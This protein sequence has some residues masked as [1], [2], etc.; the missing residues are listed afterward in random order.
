MRLIFCIAL[1]ISSCQ[2][3]TVNEIEQHTSKNSIEQ[4]EKW[5][6]ENFDEYLL[7]MNEMKSLLHRDFDV[8]INRKG[9]GTFCIFL[10]EEVLDPEKLV[11]SEEENL[12]F[13]EFFTDGGFEM[14]LIGCINFLN[15]QNDITTNQS[16]F[17]K[18]F[19]EIG[20]TGIINLKGLGE[21][22]LKMDNNEFTDTI[23]EEITISY[24][25]L[26][27]IRYIYQRY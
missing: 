19:S 21:V 5:F 26:N 4:F 1:L 8:N 23:F 6:A 16:E 27:T 12:K 3:S 7:K 9:L 13:S 20:T 18:I 22:V 2:N 25:F 15:L 17:L 14:R 24:A 10:D 11:L